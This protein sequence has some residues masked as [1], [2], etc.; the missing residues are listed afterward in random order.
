[1][2]PAFF[3]RVCSCSVVW[4]RQ[5]ILTHASVDVTIILAEYQHASLEGRVFPRSEQG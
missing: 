3:V 2:C 1:M 5:A 4:P